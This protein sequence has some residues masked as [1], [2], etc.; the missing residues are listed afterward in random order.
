MKKYICVRESIFRLFR[1]VSLGHLCSNSLI[2]CATTTSRN[3][4]PAPRCC[5]IACK[6]A[7]F[8]WPRLGGLPYPT[9]DSPP[10]CKQ[11][12]NDMNNA[13][14]SNYEYLWCL[15][16]IFGTREKHKGNSSAKKL[17]NMDAPMC[18][19]IRYKLTHFLYIF[20]SCVPKTM[21]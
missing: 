4:T 15:S 5:K 10:P 7:L 14:L 13:T 12:H 8:F 16:F 3:L 11:A 2:V 6:R 19:V 20:I 1:E 18:L 21:S 9:W 17:K